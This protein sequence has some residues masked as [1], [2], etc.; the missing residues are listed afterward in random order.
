MIL[1][2]FLTSLAF[3][4]PFTVSSFNGDSNQ[5]FSWIKDYY[6]G[7][8]GYLSWT[9]AAGY[10]QFSIVHIFSI[11]IGS[12]TYHSPKLF[13][14]IVNYFELLLLLISST[15]FIRLI[16][17]EIIA[18]KF[19]IWFS[20]ISFSIVIWSI[21]CLF[22]AS[23]QQQ[24][25]IQA[26]DLFLSFVD[27]FIIIS[28]GWFLFILRQIFI[29]K[30]NYA[31]HL[32][33]FV[34]YQLYFS[35]T[36]LRFLSGAILTEIVLFILILLVSSKKQIESKILSKKNQKS[37]SI[38]DT[39]DNTFRIK[40]DIKSIIV[41]VFL[42]IVFVVGYYGFFMLEPY[43]TSARFVLRGGET[44]TAQ[45]F[46]NAIDAISQYFS[47]ENMN[48]ITIVLRFTYIFI[49]CCGLKIILNLIFNKKINSFN[50][51]V[52]ELF[53]VL[54]I[55][56]FTLV[57]FA[58]LF[59][60][61]TVFLDAPVIAH[62]Y[63]LS[64]IFAFFAVITFIFANIKKVQQIKMIS[65][66]GLLLVSLFSMYYV[67]T[68]KDVLFPNSDLLKCIMINKDK[69][70]L[71]NGMGDFWIVNPLMAQTSDIRFSVIGSMA[72][73]LDYNWQRNLNESMLDIN[74]LVYGNQDYKANMLNSLSMKLPIL[75]YTDINCGDNTGI[76]TFDEQTS[77]LIDQFRNVELNNSKSWL[78]ITNYG[79]GQYLWGYMPWNRDFINNYHEY[80]YYG[81][82]LRRISQQASYHVNSDFSLDIKAEDGLYQPQPAA[83]TDMVHSGK[84]DYYAKINY[85]LDGNDAALII[86]NLI[87]QQPIANV[88]LNSTNQNQDISFH[89]D[90]VTPISALVVI[91]PRS[92]LTLQ[93]LT[94]GKQVK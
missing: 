17:P 77:N 41:L 20:G 29:N 60:H 26:T 82:F 21:I 92:N 62:Y 43:S 90:D 1:I 63:D 52:H 8:G 78:Y 14:L 71:K 32:F 93:N 5:Y 64:V 54:T 9:T 12:F 58:G 28:I 15:L 51:K 86:I 57:T 87:T 18:N 42:S 55:I 2:L 27:S 85:K 39:Y 40:L 33:F 66:V 68:K 65:L 50:L 30:K 22:T 37:L 91:S 74:F 83:M 7:H 3:I 88:S 25:S 46:N 76:I 84:G 70:Q 81:S 75:N 11:L 35:L 69:Y 67:N 61:G 53:S 44:T 36:T 47:F 56:N 72:T 6:T 31:L 49:L 59:S 13:Y 45:A 16:K 80:F 73:N 10:S 34:L 24:V 48:L 4:Y 89:L 23:G 38:N 94:L 19:V 79:T